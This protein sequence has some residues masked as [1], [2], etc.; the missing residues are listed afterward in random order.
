[1]LQVTLYCVEQCFV[2]CV[3]FKETPFYKQPLE[4]GGLLSN[5]VDTKHDHLVSNAM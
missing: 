2:D 5:R 3:L 4:D 1:M